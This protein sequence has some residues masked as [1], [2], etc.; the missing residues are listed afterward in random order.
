ME[1]FILS[2]FK[3]QN[4]V[5]I[6]N[7]SDN[8]EETRK[9]FY[10]KYSDL[11]HKVPDGWS[12]EDRTVYSSQPILEKDVNTKQTLRITVFVEDDGIRIL[13][14]ITEDKRDSYEYNLLHQVDK[15]SPEDTAKDIVNE[16]IPKYEKEYL[17]QS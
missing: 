16:L 9:R 11:D 3:K 15:K 1:R 13:T 4:M 17:K 6:K 7:T 12:F 8:E 5:D 10:E 2:R 14:V